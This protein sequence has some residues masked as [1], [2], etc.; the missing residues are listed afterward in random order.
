MTCI[1]VSTVINLKAKLCSM[2]SF[3]WSIVMANTAIFKSDETSVFV[4]VTRTQ[5]FKRA[6]EDRH[7]LIHRVKNKHN[8]PTISK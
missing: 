7:V 5:H 4:C 6:R 8:Y 1:H 3:F 2:K